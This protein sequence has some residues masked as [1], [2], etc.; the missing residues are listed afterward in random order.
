M[1]VPESLI[2]NVPL[3]KGL[4]PEDCRKVAAVLRTKTL[5]KGEVLFRRGDE[6]TAL[7]LIDSGSVKVTRK[8]VLEDEIILAILAKGDFLGEMA[9]L[10]GKPRSADVVALDTTHVYILCRS[11]FISFVMKNESAVRAILAALSDRLRK[12][13][14]F[15]EDSVFLSVSGR[16]AKKLLEMAESQQRESGTT[17]Q[18]VELLLTQKDLAA[19]IGAKRESVNKAIKGWREKGLLLTTGNKIIVKDV[20]A[21]RKKVRIFGI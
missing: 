7:F 19:T 4:Q 10:D 1:S 12:A 17:G 20:E 13:D 9:L 5:K 3:F 14:D 2:K 11:D 21:L 16:L 15:L 6:G 18:A 8:S